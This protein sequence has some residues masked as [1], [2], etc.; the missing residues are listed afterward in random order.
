MKDVR[1]I[2]RLMREGLREHQAGRFV[3]AARFYEAVL[4][5][6][7]RHADGLHLLGMVA[8]QGRRA[9]LA[10]D[11]I[12]GAIGINGEVAAYHSNL[13]TVLQAQGRLA[14]AAMASRRALE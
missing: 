7:A 12:W 1:E 6:D 3:E 9:D 4:K 11:M 8:F 5:L 14:D 13:G 2:E 10:I